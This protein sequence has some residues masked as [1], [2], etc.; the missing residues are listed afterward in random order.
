VTAFTPHHAV[1]AVDH[2]PVTRAVATEA[3]RKEFI[4]FYCFVGVI[5]F[6]LGAA[7]VWHAFAS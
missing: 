7:Y 3:V 6:V 2:R 5:Y 4:M 1:L